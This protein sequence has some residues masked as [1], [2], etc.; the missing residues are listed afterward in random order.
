MWLNDRILS[1]Q[2]AGQG[3]RTANASKRKR[4]RFDGVV[5]EEE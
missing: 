2:T 4:G 1:G 5:R 3:K